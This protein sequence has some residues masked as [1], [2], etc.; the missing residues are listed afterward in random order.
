MELYIHIPFCQTKCHFCF[1]VS[2]VGINEE[3]HQKYLEALEQEIDFRWSD[4]KDKLP[5]I[6]SLYIGGGTPSL[7]SLRQ[8][9][10][11]A[12]VLAGF[13]DLREI[14]EVTLECN[15]S[16]IDETKLKAFKEAGVNR[17]SLGIQNLDDQLLQQVGRLGTQGRFA[18]LIETARWVGFENINCDVLLGL[19]GE[20]S[21]SVEATLNRLVGMIIPHISL[22]PLVLRKN[23]RIFSDET[24][25]RE[26]LLSKPE[27]SDRFRHW[28][29]FLLDC[30]YHRLSTTH[31]AL[32]EKYEC[33]HHRKYWD[34]GNVLGFGVSAQSFTDGCY[35]KNTA[36]LDDY[37]DRV[38]ARTQTLSIPLGKPDLIR[39][40]AI[41]ALSKK[42]ELCYSSLETRFGSGS[43]Q[44]LQR[45]LLGFANAGL[46]ELSSD[47]LRLTEKGI[48]QIHL[49]PALYLRFENKDYLQRVMRLPEETS[50]LCQISGQAS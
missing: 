27:R 24:R 35:A 50:P 37:L 26:C 21:E 10:R 28:T 22:Y 48:E 5:V 30:G 44:R 43:V 42:M 4:W 18:S 6:N 45:E 41:M 8:W 2:F 12:R 32:D 46:A 39:R 34:G 3:G 25:R 9:D 16:S 1:Y 13:W 31:F 17:I 33:L 15:P 47:G 20:T 29:K 36:N 23:T 40:C 49:L 38:P 19:P 11:L 14:A 7:L